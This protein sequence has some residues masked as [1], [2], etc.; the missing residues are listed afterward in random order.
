MCGRSDSNT[1]TDHGFVIA[2]IV[3]VLELEGG[4]IQAKKKASI[5]L[6]VFVSFIFVLCFLFFVAG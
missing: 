5:F 2:S 1:A 3:S 4:L 6:C